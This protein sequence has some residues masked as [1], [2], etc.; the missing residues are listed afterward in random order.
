M[1]YYFLL[2]L[3][4]MMYKCRCPVLVICILFDKAA[5]KALGL[6]RAQG[7][8]GSLKRGGKVSAIDIYY[9]RIIHY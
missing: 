8:G 6:Y 7:Q 1:P 5:T 9:R 2:F 3:K 4:C